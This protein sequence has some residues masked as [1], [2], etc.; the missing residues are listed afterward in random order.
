MPWT[1]DDQF[2]LTAQRII[3][4]ARED[5]LRARQQWL[6]QEVE[7]FTARGLRGGA[8]LTAAETSA[9]RAFADWGSATRAARTYPTFSTARGSADLG[10]HVRKRAA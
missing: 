3:T 5:A 2:D 8:V 9:S 6:Q 1:S 4:C 7:M 10:V